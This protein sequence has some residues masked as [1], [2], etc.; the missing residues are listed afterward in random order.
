M[1][2]IFHFIF[3]LA[4]LLFSML[5]TACNGNTNNKTAKESP[6][7]YMGAKYEPPDGRVIHGLGQYVPLFYTDEENWQYVDEYRAATGHKPM[8]Y[9]VY[10]FL[11]PISAGFDL[12]DIRKILDNSGTG[13]I[14]N[15]GIDM[16]S[17]ESWIGGTIVVP[18]D[19]IL[20]GYWDI[21]IRELA[22]IIKSIGEPV[23]V[24]PGFEFGSGNHGAHA[25]D[26]FTAEE[27]KAIWIRIVNIFAEGGV[28]NVA[29]VW[30][31]VNPWMFDYMQW[32]PGDAYV[33]WWGINYFTLEQI[34]SSD[35]FLKDAKEHNKPVMICESSPI[36]NEG[37][38]NAQNWQQWYKPFFDKI[39]AFPHIKGF[40]YI[41][42][43]WDKPGF[44][45][46]WADSRI[47][48]HST[49]PEVRKNYAKEIEKGKYIHLDEYLND[50]SIINGLE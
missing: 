13:Y 29:W 45:D 30:N 5:L 36:H 22:G 40:I 3:L 50:K 38:T 17:V 35:Q 37:A 19:T 14:L 9:A 46:D 20:G 44:W 47:N 32:Y 18:A 10:A 1:T 31:T 25:A 6:I 11:D 34:E 28:E 2:K 4:V 43:P 24:R 49:D 7:C 16:H 12:P 48:N 26:D 15:V 23:Y 42:N 39:D 21:R 8:V 41:S 33:D 27:F